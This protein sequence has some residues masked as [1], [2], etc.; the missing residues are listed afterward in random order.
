MLDYSFFSWCLVDKV[1]VS[2]SLVFSMRG[3]LHTTAQRPKGFKNRSRKNSHQMSSMF[4]LLCSLKDEQFPS[5]HLEPQME[6]E[7]KIK[8]CSGNVFTCCTI[9]VIS[10]CWREAG[11]PGEDSVTELV[12]AR[13]LCCKPQRIPSK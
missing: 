4:P 3:R 12:L 11:A 2:I 9:A 5:L 6:N 8:M 7:T 10:F 1:E 13:P